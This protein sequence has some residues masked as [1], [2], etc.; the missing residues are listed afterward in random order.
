MTRLASRFPRSSE[1]RDRPGVSRCVRHRY[2]AACA[3]PLPVHGVWPKG[4]ASA[5]SG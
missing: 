5:S 4:D 3:L 2:Q 1:Q